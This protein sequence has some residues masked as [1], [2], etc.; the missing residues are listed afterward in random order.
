MKNL[1]CLSAMAVVSNGFVQQSIHQFP[2]TSSSQVNFGFF[3]SSS[4]DGDKSEKNLE[5]KDIGLKGLAQLITAGM[6]APF[7]GDYQ[8]V[9]KE[10]GKFMF[11]LEANN[12]VDENGKSKQTSMP[13]KS[14][15]LFFR[16]VVF[17]FNL[18]YLIFVFRFLI[19]AKQN[20]KFRPSIYQKI[21]RADGYLK[22]TWQ[23]SRRERRRVSNSLGRNESYETTTIVILK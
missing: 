1:I 13:C 23:R 19:V 10:T 21:L 18:I 4:D 17:S 9:D 12:L 2:R 3:P 15:H 11:S 20:N 22:K 14:V 8:G 5:K 7:L 16:I 6:G